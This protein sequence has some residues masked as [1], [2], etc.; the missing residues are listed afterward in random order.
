MDFYDDED[1]ALEDHKA[2]SA[3]MRFSRSS[4]KSC[5]IGPYEIIFIVFFITFCDGNRP[6]SA[7]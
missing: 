1:N 6:K 7:E 2:A 5:N 4:I 3:V